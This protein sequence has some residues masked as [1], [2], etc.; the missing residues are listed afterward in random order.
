MII[1]ITIIIISI[2]IV[3]II[4]I[5]F[6]VIIMIMINAPILNFS[7]KTSYLSILTLTVKLI[8][9]SFLNSIN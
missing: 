9:C 5:V 1:I 7:S 4:I 3:T 6:I 8:F 2:I